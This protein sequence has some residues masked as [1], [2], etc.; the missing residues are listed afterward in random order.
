M[1]AFLSRKTARD[2]VK[3]PRRAHLQPR[4]EVL[5]GRALLTLVGNFI[6]T[7]VTGATRVP[8]TPAVATGTINLA[9][10]TPA[11]TIDNYGDVVGEFPGL[12]VWR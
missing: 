2:R 11:G 9:P 7:D 8:V 6:G 12:G 4:L 3:G 1:S 10:V 5:E